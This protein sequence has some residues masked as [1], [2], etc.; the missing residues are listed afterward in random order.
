MGT[1]D[2]VTSA[3]SNEDAGERCRSPRPSRPPTIGVR[4]TR[5]ID[6]ERRRIVEARSA[7]LVCPTVPAAGSLP[8][9][10]IAPPV[11][12]VT[13]SRAL[14]CG[15]GRLQAGCGAGPSDADG[16]GGAMIRRPLLSSSS[17][18]YEAQ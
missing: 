17:A 12:A 7:S 14:S 3:R 2:S 4:C 8:M 5:A 11:Q 18:V 9:R 16:A 13:G 6:A 10:S 1:Q 15:F